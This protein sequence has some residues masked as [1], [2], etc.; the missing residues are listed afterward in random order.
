MTF[1]QRGA[2]VIGPLARK[3]GQ[4]LDRIGL[5]IEGESAYIERLLPATR[6]IPHKSQKPKLSLDSFVAP[7]ASL[8]GDVEIGEGS[9][10][11]YGAILRGDIHY[12]KVGSQCSIGDGTVVHVAKFAGDAPT[13]IGNGVNVG[14]KAMLHAC[15]LEDGCTVGPGSI[16]LDGA[17]VSKGAVLAAGSLA[18]HNC[19][20]PPGQV[21]AGTPAKYVRDVSS[22][23]SV[24]LF[25]SLAESLRLVPAHANEAQK[26]HVTL[27]IE[28]QE[29]EDEFHRELGYQPPP[30][31]KFGELE[32]PEDVEGMG[33]PGLI[34]ANP[35]Q[36][37]ETEMSIFSEE[38]RHVDESREA[39][40][41]RSKK[42]KEQARITE[43]MNI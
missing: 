9:S 13:I 7:T 27:D 39:Q 11:W 34:F 31:K 43:G 12:I 5:Q 26:S 4:Y 25:E 1:Y 21:W 35:L 18:T 14:A 22:E 8:I 33:P 15:T 24:K 41:A 30:L 2:K 6:V 3:M 32:D 29:A 37:D 42:L 16:V 36:K 17:R 40:E 28:V 10:I 20:I 38:N 23:E 19:V